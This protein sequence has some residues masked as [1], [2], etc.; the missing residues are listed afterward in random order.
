M[1]TIREIAYE[2]Q[3]VWGEKVNYAAKPYLEALLNLDCDGNYY[4]DSGKSCALYF[5]SNARSFRGDDARRLKAEL[6]T[7]IGV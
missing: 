5:L 3:Q 7:A 4:L 2:I 1:R 6:K